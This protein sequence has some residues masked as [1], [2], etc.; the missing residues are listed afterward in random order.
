MK[1]YVYSLLVLVALVATNS[2]FA[3]Y[4]KKYPLFE[5]FTQAS[6]GPCASQNPFFQEVYYAN[7]TNLH[8]VAYHTSWPGIDEMYDFNSSESDAMVD[9]YG[10]TGVPDMFQNGTEIGSPA[11]VTQ[12]IVDNLLTESSPIRILVTE[13]TA[14]TTRNVHIEVQTVNTI[15]AGT[16]KLKAAV[17]EREVT[18]GSPPGTNG[19]TFFPNVFRESITGTGGV[20]IT[21]A[22]VGSSVSFDYSYELD[23]IYV[24]DEIYTLAW[25]QNSS[26]KEVLNSGA[27][28]D[29]SVEVV[30][31]SL[32]SFTQGTVGGAQEFSGD[33]INIGDANANIDITLESNQ[34][35][36]WS[37]SYTYNGTEYTSTASVSINAMA[38]LPIMLNVNVGPTPAIGEYKITVE[39]PDNPELTPQ[40]L[41]FYVISGVTDLIVNNEVAYG[42]GTPYDTYDFESYYSDGLSAAGSTA[43]AVTSHFTMKKGFSNNALTEVKSIYYNVAWTFPALVGD[44]ERIMQLKDY[45]DNGGNLFISGQD[46]GWEVNEYDIYYPEAVDFYNNYLHAG[47]VT[48][49]A[50]G[51]TTFTAVTEDEWYGA[52]AESDISKPY[53]TTYYYPD[54][55]EMDGNIDEAH[56]IF[57]YNSTASKVGGIRSET[58]D[59]KT[60]YLGIGLE[61]VA[62]EAVRNAIMD[63][64]YQ[65]FKG[66]LN[67]IDYDHAIQNLLGNAYPNPAS[68]TTNIT[69]NNVD[70]D[71]VIKV[72]DITGNVVKQENVNAGTTNYVLSLDGLESGMYFYF[73]TDGMNSTQTQKL[74]V[75]K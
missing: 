28:G 15:P 54:Q 14:G 63:A 25:V 7:E 11:G 72:T 47:F 27:T 9:Y 66:D 31:V 53:G 59:Y 60:V 71:Y 56:E 5:H 62:D 49:A 16:Y 51:A 61:M 46:I 8:H 69:L 48:D 74:N 6:C 32:A 1:K 29:P 2:T 34:P 65:Y 10:V 26:T 36:D 38:S 12:E 58:D 50:S 30:P 44:E 4:A 55:I 33:V 23:P 18:Y 67:G 22:A 68:S 57:T 13:T 40:T 43:Y 19:E 39:F 52:I 64:T 45:L 21:P 41:N 70:K 17:V 37:A 42:D 73:L 35:G 20:T 3:Q 75:V 24:A